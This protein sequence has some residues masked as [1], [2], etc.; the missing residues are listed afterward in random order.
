MAQV[1]I[2]TIITVDGHEYVVTELLT[3]AGLAGRSLKL[4]A[5]DKDTAE[6][7]QKCMIESETA[8]SAQQQV[9]TKLAKMVEDAMGGH[10]GLGS[11]GGGE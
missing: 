8:Q 10:G 2:A 6:H 4:I 1:E 3:S 9:M 11:F 7:Q 5:S